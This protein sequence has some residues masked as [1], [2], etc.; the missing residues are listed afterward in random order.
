MTNE[1]S[2]H[3]QRLGW[4]ALPITVLAIL[5]AGS[6]FLLVVLRWFGFTERFEVLE[7]SLEG[8]GAALVRGVILF[9]LLPLV[10]ATVGFVAFRRGE[11]R[12]TLIVYAIIGVLLAVANL[13]TRN[14]GL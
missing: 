1:D 12:A 9:L 13:A 5:P 14:A 6:W 10:G 8:T 11:R 4:I 2:T 7:S 3:G